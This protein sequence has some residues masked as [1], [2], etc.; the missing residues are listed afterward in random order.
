MGPCL[1]FE[2]LILGMKQNLFSFKWI[3]FFSA[4]H[5][6]SENQTYGLLQQFLLV[7]VCE[8]HILPKYFSFFIF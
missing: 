2:I 1:Y 5:E 8:I 6:E 7:L 3:Y 4:T